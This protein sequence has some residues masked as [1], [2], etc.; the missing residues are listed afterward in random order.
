[1]HTDSCIWFSVLEFFSSRDWCI[2]TTCWTGYWEELWNHKPCRTE[3][4]PSAHWVRVDYQPP[5][6]TNPTLFPLYSPHTLTLP[7]ILPLTYTPEADCM[8]NE[9]TSLHAFETWKEARAT[10]GWSHN[11]HTPHIQH[12]KLGRICETAVQVTAQPYHLLK[13]QTSPE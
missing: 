11:T 4:A 10:S 9:P 6:Y 2:H 8:A 12:Q 13:E 3:T 5:I 7:N 1:M